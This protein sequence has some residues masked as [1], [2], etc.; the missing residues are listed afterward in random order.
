MNL[1]G[2]QRQSIALARA[3]IRKPKILMLDE[4]T[5]SMDSETEQKVTENLFKLPYKPTIIISTHRLQNLI[6][7]DKIGILVNGQIA[8]FGPTNEIIQQQNNEK[9]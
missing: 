1:S 3:L 4:P 9:A 7:T 8:R 5:S 2:G 6:N